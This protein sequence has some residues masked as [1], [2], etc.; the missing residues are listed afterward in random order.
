MEKTYEVLVVGGG[1]AGTATAK[2][3]AEHGISVALLEK[4]VKFPREKL[5]GGLLTQK[6]LHILQH[7]FALSQET[8]QSE[9][10]IEYSTDS[11]AFFNKDQ[12]ICRKQGI[13]PFVLI[14]RARLDF[15][16][17][18]VAQ[19]AGVDIIQGACATHCIPARGKV[20][21]QEHGEF[22][23]K[24]I[25][26]ADGANSRMRRALPINRKSWRRNLAS[27]VEIY[28]P[29]NKAP[30]A[31]HEINEP[32]LY[33]GYMQTGYGWIFPG[34][35]DL[36]IG[37]CGLQHGQKAGVVSCFEEFLGTLGLNRSQVELKGHPLPYGNWLKNPTKERLLLV[38][39]AAG[40]VEPL[41]GEGIFYALASGWYA[42]H[43]VAKALGS[44]EHP[45][46]YYIASLK[47]YI[48][49]EFR[50]ANY[51]R[52]MLLRSMQG[53]GYAPFHG[54]MRISGQTLLSVVHGRRS[55]RCFFSKKWGF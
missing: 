12:E 27:A 1:P 8:L 7:I 47:K 50:W 38:G 46:K 21:T 55:W 16:L 11:Y 28:L 40:F 45:A 22:R 9:K 26:A 43:A 19:K 33:V 3:L 17:L 18:L 10:I 36:R 20:F 53:M 54:L 24:Y 5:C 41:L 32:R 49:P 34:L 14:N 52:Q 15:T 30:E 31:L 48:F 44:G 6:T 39:D 29:K 37:M 25:I 23:A 51:L 13:H 42:G 35:H 4:S 2:I